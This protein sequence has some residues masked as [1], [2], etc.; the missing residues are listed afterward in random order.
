MG[1]S[2]NSANLVSESNIFVDITNDRVGIGSTIPTSKL[3]V[4]GDIRT[5]GIVSATGGF[6][7]GIQ[8]AGTPIASGVAITAL[9]FIGAGNTFSYNSTTKTVDISIQGGGGGGSVSGGGTFSSN[10]VG[11]FTSKLLGINTTTVIGSANSEGAIQAVGNITLLDG[12]L[13]TDQNIDTNIFVPTGKNGLLI[14]P[15][16]VGVGITIDVAQG[17][18][19]VVV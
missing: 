9:N 11:V 18:T 10:N 15:V 12:A 13:I 16:T 8:S 17:S 3:D 6:N 1:K 2:R 5:T 4:V 7:I 14:G 19:L